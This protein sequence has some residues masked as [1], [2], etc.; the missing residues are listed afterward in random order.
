MSIWNSEGALVFE[1]IL[2]FRRERI[3]PFETISDLIYSRRRKKG[4]KN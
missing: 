1:T 2:Q 3:E 4:R